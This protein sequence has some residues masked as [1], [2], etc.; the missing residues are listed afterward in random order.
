MNPEQRSVSPNLVQALVAVGSKLS[1]RIRS[2]LRGISPR[3]E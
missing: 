1:P 2:S 3:L